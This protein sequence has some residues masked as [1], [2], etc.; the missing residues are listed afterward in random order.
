MHGITHVPG[1]ADPIPGLQISPSFPD[2]IAE[3]AA[4][5]DL[6]G[7][8]RL[9]DGGLG[10]Y[11]DSKGASSWANTPMA[12]VDATVNMTDIDP[13]ALTADDDG[14]VRF[15]DTTGAGSDWLQAPNTWGTSASN[16]FTGD[17]GT[18]AGWIRPAASTSTFDA[19]M[20]S[21][22]NDGAG[23]ITGVTV[24][25]AWPA[26]TVYHQRATTRLTGPVLPA[27]TWAFLAG[28]KDATST[29]IYV[30]GALVATGTAA[31]G[32]STYNPPP[33]IG[34]SAGTI[35]YGVLY[36]AVDEVSVWGGALTADE[37][38]TLYTAAAGTPPPAPP[39]DI[40]GKVDRDAVELA[41][42]RLVGVKLAAGD[43]QRSFRIAGDG[44]LA[45]G[46]GGTTA[47]DV[48]L[49]RATDGNLKTDS[50]IRAV[51]VATN[52]GS[53]ANQLLLHQDGHIYF[54]SGADTTMYRTDVNTL[55]TPGDFYIGNVWGEGSVIVNSSGGGGRLYFGS[56]LDTNLFRSTNN[57]LAS[58]DEFECYFAAAGAV[59]R[60]VVGSADSGGAGYRMVRV[61]N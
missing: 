18:V 59:R 47:P 31:V 54:G 12:R 4:T 46:Q 35:P 57:V 20:F 56:A 49:Y 33:M 21:T 5:R 29:R 36:G 15:N 14:A 16:P 39:V 1:G 30:N 55:R 2:A 60:L 34:S 40:S 32:T 52:Q 43:T 26:R 38:A 6:R 3:L 53:T 13:G 25:V 61:A 42:A 50:G 37:I 41:T 23:G 58:D 27:D 8:W 51:N 9:G 22:L 17:L 45:W 24:G 7:Y 19:G 44:T 11:A 10:P 48:N 28:V